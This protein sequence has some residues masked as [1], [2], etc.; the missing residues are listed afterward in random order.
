[1]FRRHT[2]NSRVTELDPHLWRMNCQRT[3][4]S[5]FSFSFSFLFFSFFFF[6][7]FENKMYCQKDTEPCWNCYMHITRLTTCVAHSFEA[8]VLRWTVSNGEGQ[9]WLASSRSTESLSPGQSSDR[10]QSMRQQAQTLGTFLH[11]QRSQMKSSPIYRPLHQSDWTHAQNRPA[12][13]QLAF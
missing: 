11:Y 4:F 10:S 8:R 3:H 9:R 13:K 6:F 7:F 1:M 2:V 12:P 5:F